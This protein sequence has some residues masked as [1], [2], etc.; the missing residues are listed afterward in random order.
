[1]P[2]TQEIAHSLTTS[3]Q[4]L[5]LDA[6]N[7]ARLPGDSLKGVYGTKGDT[8]L[9]WAHHEKLCLIDGKIAFMGGLDLCFGRWDTHQHAIADVHPGDLQE[10]VFPGQDYNNARVLDFQNVAHWEQNQLT[11]TAT[12]RMGWSDISISLRGP[13]IEDLRRHFVD[14]WNYIF[15]TKYYA[16]NEGR[17]SKLVLYGSPS[18]FPGRPSDN[19]SSAY[20]QPTS[21]HPQ[22]DH[23]QWQAQ[24]ASQQPQ[25]QPQWQQGQQQQQQQQPQPAGHSAPYYPSPSGSQDSQQRYQYASGAYGSQVAPTYG[26]DNQSSGPYYPPPPPGPPPAQM[27][28]AYPTQTS[29]ANYDAYAH[30]QQAY[31]PGPYGSTTPQPT[32]QTQAPSFPPPPGQET[33]HSQSRGLY[34]GESITRAPTDAQVGVRASAQRL[35]GDFTGFSQS[36][37]GQLAGQVHQYQDRYINNQGRLSSPLGNTF[38]QVVRSCTTWSGGVPTEHSIQDAYISIIRES[39]HFVYIENQFF[40]TATSDAQKPVGNKI[41]AA[42]VERILRAAR[43]GQKYK[44]IVIIPSV[45]GFAGDLRDD[46][47]LGTRAIMEFQYNSISRGGHSIMEVIAKEGYNPMEYIRFYNLRNYDRINTNSTMLQAEQRSG[48]AYEDARR[49]HDAAEVGYGGYGPGASVP[50]R[51]FDTTQPYER[52][53][54][55]AQQVASAYPSNIP[56]RWDSVSECYMLGGEDIRNVPWDSDLPEIDAFVSEELYIHSKVTH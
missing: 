21:V 41:G 28:S 1:M 7:I 47:A 52:Y 43:A 20:N 4:N 16:R 54:Q 36:L 49:Y 22:Q 42:I 2:D 37:R 26:A 19:P 12:A 56:G 25:Q 32:Q 15:D 40:I 48:V 35:M 51:G 31:S 50:S 33:Q 6:A 8:V 44:I 23:P 3:L 27:S 5:S 55:A 39:E 29:P 34:D 9:F 17:Y 10:I 46:S 38:C 11:R 13:V 18:S 14:R 53:Q 45:P 30:T 24:A